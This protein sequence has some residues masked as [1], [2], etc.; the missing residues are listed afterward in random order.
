MRE[1]LIFWGVE[2]PFKGLNDLK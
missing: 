2:Y 1:Y